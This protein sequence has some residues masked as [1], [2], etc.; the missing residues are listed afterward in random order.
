MKPS[1]W[2]RSARKQ[3]IEPAVL[4][5]VFDPFHEANGPPE[6]TAGLGLSIA[7]HMVEAH[8]GATFT[9]M[10]PDCASQPAAVLEPTHQCIEADADALALRPLHRR[11]AE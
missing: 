2:H 9:V 6:R 3:G 4:P 7:T 8:G 1:A 11:P 10:P 5:H